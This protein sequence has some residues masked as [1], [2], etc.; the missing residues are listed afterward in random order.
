MWLGSLSYSASTP[1]PGET[2]TGEGGEEGREERRNRGEG[3]GGWNTAGMEKG[4]AKTGQGRKR[5]GRR[6]CRGGRREGGSELSRVRISGHLLSMWPQE[7]L[8][9]EHCEATRGPRDFVT[10]KALINFI[11]YTVCRGKNKVL[12]SPLTKMLSLL[13][14]CSARLP[15]PLE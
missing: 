3:G 6:R 9:R 7:Q 5:G 10:I 14:E 15:S 8:Q 1:T 2:R 12:L 13:Y 4:V 11:K